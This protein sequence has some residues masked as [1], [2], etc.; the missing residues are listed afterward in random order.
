MAVEENHCGR[1]VM[2]VID[3]VL[4]V[5]KTLAAF[6]LRGVSSRVHVIDGVDEIAPSGLKSAHRARPFP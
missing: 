3:D 5:G 4:K 6:V 1:E 2:V